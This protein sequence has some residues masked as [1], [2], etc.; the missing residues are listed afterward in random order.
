MIRESVS[1]L[2]RSRSVFP[3]HPEL[4]AYALALPW[5]TVKRSAAEKSF[6]AKW[7]K[8]CRNALA[9]RHFE[10]ISL[11]QLALV[12]MVALRAMSNLPNGAT[13][14]ETLLGDAGCARRPQGERQHHLVKDLILAQ[15]GNSK[16][17]EILEGPERRFWNPRVKRGV[18]SDQD[19]LDLAGFLL[20]AER[21]ANVPAFE[22]FAAGLWERID[23]K[24]RGEIGHP[25]APDESHLTALARVARSHF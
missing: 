25:R 21:N 9:H 14:F 10:S 23:K 17:L 7:M 11:E 1:A 20:E 6:T 13:P 8:H 18:S 3:N 19:I 12:A 24:C 16:S 5:D 22:L 2:L 4:I 15:L